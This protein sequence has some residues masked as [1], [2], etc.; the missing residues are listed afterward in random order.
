MNK[1]DIINFFFIGFFV[2]IIACVITIGLTIGVRIPDGLT[3]VQPSPSA[4]NVRYV[5][6]FVEDDTITV[7]CDHPDVFCDDEGA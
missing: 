5:P 2:G 7:D 6:V 1:S 3:R 4:P